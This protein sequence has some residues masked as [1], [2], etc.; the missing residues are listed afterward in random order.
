[1]DNNEIIQAVRNIL[2]QKGLIT[3]LEGYKVLLY[4]SR[5]NNTN[6]QKSD[7]DIGILG[8]KELPAKVFFEIEDALESLPT[9][10]KF[11]LVDLQGTSKDF[12]SNIL[13]NTQIIYE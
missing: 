13:K 9:L 10:L 12:Q 11:D 1:M 7:I 5:A 2:L 4:G 3:K 6:K 8:Q